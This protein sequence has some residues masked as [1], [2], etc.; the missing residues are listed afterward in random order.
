MHATKLHD[1]AGSVL[2]GGA[3]VAGQDSSISDA[4]AK[5]ASIRAS[6]DIGSLTVKGSIVGNAPIAGGAAS[7]IISA[8]GKPGPSAATTA[9]VAIGRITI[10]G[11]LLLR[12]SSPARQPPWAPGD[13][14]SF[15][16]HAFEV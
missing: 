10:G 13:P 8:R 4:L 1:A 15:D 3:I 7:V 9:D 16:F 12:R 6:G 11:D 5:D 14:D 2:S